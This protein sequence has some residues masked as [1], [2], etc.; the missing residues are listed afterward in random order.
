MI[1]KILRSK[2]KENGELW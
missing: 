2:R 1:I